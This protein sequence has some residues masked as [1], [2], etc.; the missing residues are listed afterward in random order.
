MNKGFNYLKKPGFVLSC[1][2]LF[3]SCSVY[4]K[5]P[6]SLEEAVEQEGK[7]KIRTVEGKNIK[8]KK[9]AFAEG[10]FYGTKMISGK[11]ARISLNQDNIES[12]R[13]KNKSDSAWLTVLAIVVPVGA[14]IILGATADYGGGIS[15]GGSY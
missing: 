11:W 10:Q 7:V 12:V 5:N 4:Y 8:Y 14:L 6:I 15:L 3:Q 2:F 13:L 9:I 1:L